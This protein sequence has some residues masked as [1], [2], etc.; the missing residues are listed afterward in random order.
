M[1][2]KIPPPYL[3]RRYGNLQILPK[4]T[5]APAADRTKP[6]FPEKLLLFFITN[7]LQ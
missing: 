3:A 4:P 6:N 7:Y 5:D 2:R 1:S